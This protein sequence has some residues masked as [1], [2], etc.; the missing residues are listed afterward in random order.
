MYPNFQRHVPYY[1]I[2]YIHIP[3]LVHNAYDPANT[4]PAT[5]AANDSDA[6]QWP[7]S[8][9]LLRQKKVDG[10]YSGDCDLITIMTLWGHGMH[11]YSHMYVL[12]ILTI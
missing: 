2:E 12:L 3:W 5:M 11:N 6:G 7:A 9:K 10:F 1:S 4:G 8:L